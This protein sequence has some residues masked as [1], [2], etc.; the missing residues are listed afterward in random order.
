MKFKLKE[1]AGDHATREIVKHEGKPDTEEVVVY[2]PGDIIE[3]DVDLVKQH[4]NKFV[5]VGE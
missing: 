2:K 3:S 5:K 1:G 4:P